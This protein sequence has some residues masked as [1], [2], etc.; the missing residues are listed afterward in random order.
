[1]A[2]NL[3]QRHRIVKTG[4]RLP[5]RR[6]FPRNRD[7]DPF[8]EHPRG[9]A[10]L[11]RAKPPVAGQLL[12]AAAG[13]AAVQAAPHGRRAGEVFPDCQVFPRRG[14]ARRPPAGIHP[15][16]HRGELH[17]ARGHHHAGRGDVEARLPGEHRRGRADPVPAPEPRR[18][19][20]PLRQ[21][22]AR[23]PLRPGDRGPGRRVRAKRVQ[24]V[25]GRDGQRRRGP[26]DQ[27]EAVRGASP[28]ARS[29]S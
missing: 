17:R 11:P 18:G 16:R 9:R 26:G 10:R 24:G 14:P 19:H 23:H 25:P 1:M 5:R 28:R 6:R 29:R 15:D 4:A 3:K 7:A 13:S 21:R 27:R 2:T 8:Q 22:Q 12:R 20:G